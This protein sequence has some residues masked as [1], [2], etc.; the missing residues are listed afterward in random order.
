MFC[1]LA[2][3]QKG[4][5]DL[6]NEAEFT[7]LCSRMKDFLGQKK[8]FTVLGRRQPAVSFCPITTATLFF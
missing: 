1:K 7:L 2:E 3:E 5:L 8:L 4:A 6:N